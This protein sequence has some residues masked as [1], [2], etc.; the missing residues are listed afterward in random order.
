MNIVWSNNMPAEHILCLIRRWCH[1][2]WDFRASRRDVANIETKRPSNS[3]HALLVSR[4]LLV[5]TKHRLAW[6]KNYLFLDV[7]SCHTL[8]YKSCHWGG[9]RS[10]DTNIYYLIYIPFNIHQWTHK[11]FMRRSG[12]DLSWGRTFP[13]EELNQHLG[14]IWFCQLACVFYHLCVY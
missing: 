11:K 9:T 10:Q 4:S 8:R 14:L 3:S 13:S 6:N 12:V 1:R 5:R 2:I 7:L